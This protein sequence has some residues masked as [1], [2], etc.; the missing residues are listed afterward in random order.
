MPDVFCVGTALLG[1]Q[2]AELPLNKFH[3]I[4]AD[5][6]MPGHISLVHDWAD[7]I[8][9]RANVTRSTDARLAPVNVTIISRTTTGN[10]RARFVTGLEELQAQAEGLG[11]RAYI[12]DFAEVPFRQQLQILGR[13][14]I[15]LAVHGA[16]NTLLAFLPPGAVFVELKP[17][18]FNNRNTHFDIYT[19]WAILAQ[20]RHLVWHNRD[21]LLS[22]VSPGVAVDDYKNH[23][24]HLSAEASDTILALALHELEALQGE[25]RS[26]WSPMYINGARD[27]Y[28]FQHN[29][30]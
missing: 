30:G 27:V 19:N 22:S 11:L 3:A 20:V 29:F 10:T 13:T 25:R 28:D 7:W 5:E 14:S 16:A 21:A 23:N 18:K 9:R 6:I 1:A 8:L 2:Q 17:Y 24:T 26:T 15:F 12:Y 4:R